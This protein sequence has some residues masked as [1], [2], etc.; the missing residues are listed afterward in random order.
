MDNREYREKAKRTLPDLGLDKA[1]QKVLIMDR[2]LGDKMNLAHMVFGLGGEIGELISCV[3]TELKNRIDRVNLGEELGDLYWYISNYCNLRS[4][5]IPEESS[6]VIDVPNDECLELLIINI[7]DLTDLVKRYI[8]YGKAIE[9]PKE[10]E[11]VYNIYAALHLFETLYDIEGSTVRKR[12]IDKLKVRYPD[13]Y[14][15]TAALNRDLNAEKR[16]LQ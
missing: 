4:L 15:D 5:P 6:I 16:T 2:E 8:A 13:R 14:T 3:G 1:E 11:I 9:K 10:L 7:A 12:N